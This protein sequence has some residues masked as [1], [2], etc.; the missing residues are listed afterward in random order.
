M[1]V[2][3]LTAD[4]GYVVAVALAFYLQQ[5]II[6][7]IPIG[8]TRKATGIQPP[9]LYPRDS[10]IKELKLSDS[11][12]DRYMRVQ[13]VHQNSLEFLAIFLPM[14]LVAGLH[15]PREAAIAGA[16]TWVGRLF[17]GVGYWFSA[18]GRLMGGWFHLGEFYVLY[19]VGQFAYT[20]IRSA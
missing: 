3:E 8:I 10:Q 11:K 13:R 9:T 7:V 4:F 16:V 14:L 15:A 12:V 2:L 5:A 18:K 1:P 17:T 20:L 19:L 6:F